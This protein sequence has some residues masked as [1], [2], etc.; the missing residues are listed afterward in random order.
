M[1]RLDIKP[2]FMEVTRISPMT[3]RSIDVGVVL[4]MMIHDIDIVLRLANSSRDQNRRHRRQRDRRRRGHLQRP[5]HLRQR[6]RRQPHRQPAGDANRAKLCAS[7]AH[8]AY[9]SIDY[10]KRHGIVVRRSGNIDAVRQAAAK[11]RSGEI[12]IFRN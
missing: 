2:R 5:A 7:S 4:D 6:L 8:D 9:V 12:R 11:I 10:Q 1:S 3:F